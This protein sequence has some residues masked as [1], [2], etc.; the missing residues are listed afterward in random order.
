[1]PTIDVF[2]EAFVLGVIAVASVKILL[3]I[4]QRRP[5][6]LPPGPKGLPFLGNIADF[7]PEGELEWEHWLK[8]KDTYGPISSVTTFGTTFI[9]IHSPEL[10]LELLEKRSAN[11]SNRQMVELSSFAG[12]DKIVG[13]KQYGQTHRF[14]RKTL[15][16]SI[17]T[18][19]ALTSYLPLHEKE[20]HRFLFRVLQEPDSLMNHLRT[21]T[22]AIILKMAYGYTVE[23]NKPDPLVDLADQALLHLGLSVAPSLVNLVP[24]FRYIPTWVPGTSWKKAIMGWRQHFD[25]TRE[26]PFIF[27]KRRLDEG[28]SEKSFLLD[29][30]RNRGDTISPTNDDFILKWASVSMYLGGSDTTVHTLTSFFFTMALFPGVQR[31]AQEEIDQVIGTSRLPTFGDRDSLPY[32]NAVLLEAWRWHTVVPMSIPHAAN[33]EDVVN[34]FRIPKGAVIL[35]NIWWFMHDPAVYPNPSEFDPSRYLGSDPAPD[36][37][38]HIFGYGRRICPGQA[39]ADSSVWLTIAQS[40]AVFNISRGLDE[41]GREIDP[42]TQYTPTSGMVSRVESFNVTIKPRSSQHEALVREVEKLHPWEASDAEEVQ[43]I[44]I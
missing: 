41:S 24:A 35:P 4:F 19:S 20:V 37:T 44:V 39:L 28:S 8:H 11:Y 43:K 31:K 3:V 9:L 33:A 36:P 30:F 7:P 34:G 6:P 15:H 10:A 42:I 13:F 25:E 38:R 1:M 29:A 17:G 12:F 5:L 26:K 23:P 16:T 27:T 21:L 32:I 18:Q 14:M 40:L 2:V 22:G